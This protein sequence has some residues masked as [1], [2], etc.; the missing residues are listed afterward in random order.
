MWE[1]YKKKA[2][3]TVNKDVADHRLC[4]VM[5]L[6]GELAELCRQPNSEEE[7]GDVNWYLAYAEEY[8]GVKPDDTP[9][10]CWTY[11]DALY[12][13]CDMVDHYK[14]VMFQGHTLNIKLINDKIS[15]IG[16]II[17]FTTKDEVLV[18]NIEKLER[19]YKSG[20]FTANESNNRS[21]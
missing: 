5:G 17:R 20:V 6:C 11:D 9:Y 19:R 14:K 4:V 2:V 18:K 7:L 12:M 16:N 21:I 3:R 10:M 8:L 15:Y 1:E 13:A